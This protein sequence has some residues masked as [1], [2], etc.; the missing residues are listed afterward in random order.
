MTHFDADAE[1]CRRAAE[2]DRQA[3]DALV[4]AYR[5]PLYRFARRLTRDDALAEDVLQETFL[6]ALRKVGTWRGEGSCRGWLFSI[7]RT[8]AL[9]ARRRGAVGEAMEDERA[10]PELGLSAG[11]GAAMDPEAL[12]ARLEEQAL[13]ERALEGL[14]PKEREVIALRDLEGLSGEETAQVLGLSLAAMK[15][16]LHRARLELLAAVKK[17]GIDGR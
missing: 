4:V 17:G 2:G 11:W 10:L 9:M 3:M 14:G 5:G 7:A 13:L 12:A 15:S 6:T 1:L 16:R 8:Q